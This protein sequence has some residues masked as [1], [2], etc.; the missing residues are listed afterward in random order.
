MMATYYFIFENTPLASGIKTHC[1]EQNKV[2]S[3]EQ[4]HIVK[5]TR[6][7]TEHDPHRNEPSGEI[8]QWG[9]II[10]IR[11]IICDDADGRLPFHPRWLLL[12]WIYLIL[13]VDA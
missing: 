10:D 3:S 13:K 7:A 8:H 9:N 5:N 11:I 6:E 12:C 4:I 1:I 2:K